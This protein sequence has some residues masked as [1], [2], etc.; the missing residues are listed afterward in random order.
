MK[1]R[2]SATVSARQNER[3]TVMEPAYVVYLQRKPIS[4]VREI[5]SPSQRFQFEL[6]A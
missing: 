6:V 1:P 4:P 5:T 2:P 3:S